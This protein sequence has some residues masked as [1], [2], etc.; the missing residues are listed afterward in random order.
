MRMFQAITTIY[1]NYIVN[2][3]K[4]SDTLIYTHK[5]LRSSQL[6]AIWRIYAIVYSTKIP[7][8]HY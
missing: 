6:E 7:I 3:I 2:T 1:D 5:I 4:W 8:I